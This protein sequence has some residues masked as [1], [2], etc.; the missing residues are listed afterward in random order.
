MDHLC[1]YVLEH[2]MNMK[3][4]LDILHIPVCKEMCVLFVM[5]II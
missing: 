3:A 5:D 2:W 4:V 1:W